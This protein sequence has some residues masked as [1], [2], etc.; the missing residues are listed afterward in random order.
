MRGRTFRE[1]AHEMFRAAI[2][3]QSDRFHGPTSRVAA[4]A[5]LHCTLL[6]E[7]ELRLHFPH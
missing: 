5:R 3:R 2:H 4:F 7:L 6:R 1:R